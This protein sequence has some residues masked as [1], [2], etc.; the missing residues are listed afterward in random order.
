VSVEK[1]IVDQTTIYS[2]FLLTILMMIGLF[3]FIRAS[4]KDRTEQVIWVASQ[5]ETELLPQLQQYFTERAYKL[6]DIASEKKLSWEG[7]V[8]PS[9]FLG[10]FL[11]FLA[12]IGLLCLALVLSLLIPTFKAGFL[13]L[14]LLAPAA[15]IF[16]WKKAGR[17]EKVQLE[18]E[19][20]APG[21]TQLTITAHRDELI[22]LYET[23]KFRA[24]T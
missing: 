9:R 18:I 20:I 5:A 14:V 13:F 15:G 10:V 4:V 1:L 19:A 16:Y 2:T 23:G 8:R 24:L 7:F 11:S 6:T 12:A 21:Q 3:F 17:I 22:Q